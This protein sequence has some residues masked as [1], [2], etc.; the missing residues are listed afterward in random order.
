MTL[1]L[2]PAPGAVLNALGCSQKFSFLLRRWWAGPETRK[3]T[4]TYGD[5]ERPIIGTILANIKKATFAEGTLLA[6]FYIAVGGINTATAG[7]AACG[8][9]RGVATPTIKAAEALTLVVVL[10]LAASRLRLGP[11]N[12]RDRGQATAYQGS[13]HQPERLTSRDAAFSQSSSQLVEDAFFLG[14]WQSLLPNDGT[15]QPRPVDQRR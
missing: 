7:R 11:S 15:R 6:T 10:A 14:H 5:A 3:S 4:Q 8:E 13:T 9:A 12:A 2:H 1:S